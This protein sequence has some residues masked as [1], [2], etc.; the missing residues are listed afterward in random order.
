MEMLTEDLKLEGRGLKRRSRCPVLV[1]KERVLAF[2][3]PHLAARDL[4]ARCPLVE[5]V[6][7]KKYRRLQNSGSDLFLKTCVRVYSVYVYAHMYT[8]TCMYFAREWR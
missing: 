2:M 8:H 3:A 7:D 1:R 4:K 5:K 6:K